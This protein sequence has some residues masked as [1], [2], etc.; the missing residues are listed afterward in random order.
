M[1]WLDLNENP[2]ELTKAGISAEAAM[3]RLHVVDAEGGI[4]GG[5][6]ALALIWREVPSRRWLSHLM[7]IGPVRGIVARIYGFVAR[8]RVRES[9]PR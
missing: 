7:K 2:E 4:H 6:E 9:R 3:T 5:A 1:R 8:R